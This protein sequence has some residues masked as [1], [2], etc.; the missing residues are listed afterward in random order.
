[1]RPGEFSERAFL[2]DKMDLVQLEGVADLIASAS[3]QA[4]KS[5]LGSLTG[6][7]SKAVNALVTSVIELRIYIEASIDFPEEEIDF[8]AEPFVL[9]RITRIDAQLQQILKQAEQ[10]RRLQA[11]FSIALVGSPNAGKSSVLNRFSGQDSAIVTAIPGTTR[12]VIREQLLLDGYP[13]QIADTAGIREAMDAIEQEGIARSRQ[14]ALMADL[15]LWIIDVTA[16]DLTPLNLCRS[17]LEQNLIAAQA[18]LFEDDATVKRLVVL[19]KMDLLPETMQRAL[20]DLLAGDSHTFLVSAKTGLGWDHLASGIKQ[21]VGVGDDSESLFSARTRHIVALTEAAQYLTQ[22]KKSLLAGLPGE[23]M[24]E[25]LKQVQIALGEITGQV[26][27]DDLLG[28]IFSSFC[29]GK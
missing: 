14:T 29:I 4:A 3:E 19:N 11:G 24:A 20:S 26:T 7:F 15:C 6:V 21:M 8:L 28:K 2:N 1:A 12:D 18:G 22:A 17:V 5:A 16:L 9:E 25:D 27:S 10:G 13:I 23:L